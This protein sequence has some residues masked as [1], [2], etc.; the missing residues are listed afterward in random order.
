MMTWTV[1]APA[2]SAAFLSSLVEAVEALTIVLAVGTCSRLAAGG[3]WRTRWAGIACAH[4]T[5]AWPAARSRSATLFAA[6]DRGSASAVWYAL[7]AKSNPSRR[8]RYSAS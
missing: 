2:I 8:G 7:A 6:C 3:T 5:C 1:A 4:S